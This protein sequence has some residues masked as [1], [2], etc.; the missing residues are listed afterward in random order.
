MP[1]LVLFVAGSLITL[2]VIAGCLKLGRAEEAEALRRER[3]RQL[4]QLS[5]H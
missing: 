5:P 1:D 2:T 3:D 4:R